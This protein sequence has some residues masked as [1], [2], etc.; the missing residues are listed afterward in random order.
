MKS[1]GYFLKSF[2]SVPV[3]RTSSHRWYDCT[4][5]TFY[6]SVLILNSARSKIHVLWYPA[7]S[8]QFSSCIHR[9][10]RTKWESLHWTCRNISFISNASRKRKEPCKIWASAA[11]LL[12]VMWNKNVLEDDNYCYSIQF[13]ARH[14]LDTPMPTASPW[15]WTHHGS[16]G[17]FL[18]RFQII[19]KHLQEVLCNAVVLNASKKTPKPSQGSSGTEG[20]PSV[21]K[22]QDA[23][24]QGQIP[25]CQQS[26]AQAMLLNMFLWSN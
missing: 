22:G 14:I 20:H 10:L 26:P 6:Q 18:E 3:L 13:F 24:N 7:L 15:R 4:W 19:W 12:T 2:F 16:Q 17:A 23:T 1:S 21:S 25:Q 5:P 11:T 8:L 9:N